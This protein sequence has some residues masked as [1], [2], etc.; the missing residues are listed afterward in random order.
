[1]FLHW[2]RKKTILLGLS[3]IGFS[4]LLPMIST[5][6]TV[7]FISSILVGIG[8]GLFNAL[9]ISMI[10]DFYE[11]QERANLIGFRTATLNIGKALTT[12]LSGFLASYS[13][14]FIF[15]VYLLALPILFLFKTTIPELK[16]QHEKPKCSYH[17]S[18]DVIILSFIT[19]LVGISY[20]GVT[21]KLPTLLTQKYHLDAQVATKLLTLLAFSGIFSGILFGYLMKQFKNWTLIVMIALMILG[22]FLMTLPYHVLLFLLAAILVGI[23][24]VGIMSACFWLISQKVN[25]EAIN[26]ATSILLTAGNIGVILTPLILT[27]LLVSLQSEL[28]ITPFYVTTL[29]MIVCL[30]ISYYYLNISYNINWDLL[31]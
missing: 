4:G 27:K 20:I 30:L 8:I 6:Y 7:V 1:M 11:N 16:T 15:L 10:S 12:L 24:F 3:L 5:A 14:K 26:F 13:I 17:L 2:V 19:F 18:R 9:S 31:D 29:L 25:Q 28:L 23:S 22:S 21:I